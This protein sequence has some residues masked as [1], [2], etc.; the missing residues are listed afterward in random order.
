MR[1]ALE[2]D[3]LPCLWTTQAVELC[4]FILVTLFTCPHEGNYT[5]S[6]KD[7]ACAMDNLSPFL[8]S[9]QKFY[10]AITTFASSLQVLFSEVCVDS[11]SSLWE[12]LGHSTL[13]KS[14]YGCAKI[15]YLRREKHILFGMFRQIYIESFFIN[16]KM[17]VWMILHLLRHFVGDAFNSPFNTPRLSSPLLCPYCALPLYPPAWCHIWS[18]SDIG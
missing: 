13:D 1:R 16:C 9:S 14:K 2:C 11:S 12:E 8:I 18:T 6:T 3:I 7:L 15:V 5:K 10:N 4:G 17:L